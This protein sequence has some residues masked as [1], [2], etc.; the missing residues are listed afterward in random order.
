[1]IIVP[2]SIPV[3]TRPVAIEGSDCAHWNVKWE[4]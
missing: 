3:L 1:M 2:G 4:L